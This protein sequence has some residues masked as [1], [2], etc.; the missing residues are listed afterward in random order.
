M[1]RR[2]SATTARWWITSPQTKNAAR[3]PRISW[4]LFHF[5]MRM[6]Q[7]KV[8]ESRVYFSRYAG[9]FRRS[10]SEGEDGG[11]VGIFR[12]RMPIRFALRHASLKMTEEG[13]IVS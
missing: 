9:L 4:S 13:L 10:R 8:Y 12:L 7:R 1:R 3:R 6:R 11:E 2:I 5:Y